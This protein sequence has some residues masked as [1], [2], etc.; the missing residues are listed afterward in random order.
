M[1]LWIDWQVDVPQEEQKEVEELLCKAADGALAHEGV[2][3]PSEA[4]AAPWIS[5][6]SCFSRILASRS[7]STSSSARQSDFSRGIV[8][9]SSA[10]RPSSQR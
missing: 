2:D 9:S 10:S 4:T 7:C 3:T 1:D 5:S 8:I 6:M